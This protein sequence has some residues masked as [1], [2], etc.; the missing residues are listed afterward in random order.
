MKGYL[1][2]LNLFF[3]FFFLTTLVYSTSIQVKI[4][5]NSTLTKLLVGNYKLDAYGIVEI[6]NPSNISKVYE[7]NFPL[8]LDSL[9][10]ISKVNLIN[11]SSPVS[12]T[13]GEIRGQILNP[14][15]TLKFGYHIYGLLD[16]DV[17][18]H[19]VREGK[20]ILEYYTDSMNFYSNLIINLQKPQREG[21]IYNDDENHTINSTPGNYTNTSRLISSDIR[22]PTDF[23]YKINRINLFRS[24]VADPFLDSG[25][26]IATKSDI[27]IEPFSYSKFDFFDLNSNDDS[28]YWL[29]SDF[30][31]ISN[32]N[33]NIKYIFNIQRPLSSGSSSSSSGGG[34]SFS[35][36][37]TSNN[38]LDSIFIKK[39]VNKTL[40]KSGDEFKVILRVVNVND[41]SLEDLVIKDEI[42]LGYEIKDVS[43]GV[44]ISNKTQL[45]FYIDKV[46]PYETKI[47]EYTL[48]NKN[49]YRGVTY[50]KPA[51]LIVENQS[52]YSEGV[53]VVNELL[54]NKKVFV[55]KDIKI[56][57]D[58]YVKVTIKVKNLGS[59]NLN[60]LLVVDEIGDDVIL[61]DISK[62]FFERGSW[63]I[64]ELKS[65]EE[66]EVTYLAER[67]ANL[68]SLPN[69]YGVDK[70]DVYGT[71][72]SS[73]EVVTIYQDQP[74]TI[75][76]VGLGLAVGLLVIYLLF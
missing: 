73:D 64:K 3:L 38:V 22:N 43:S 1:N 40:I 76:K 2:Y 7:F 74:R 50:L 24:N 70:T 36:I 12:I 47:I 10:G 41:F 26:M 18:E 61:K 8:S 56:Y 35:G 39:S 68:D 16:Y 71:V 49:K 65:G 13:F 72:I 59:V 33:S 48:I 63:R 51:E 4:S 34:G 32:V 60:D 66:W 19:S 62:V 30:K 45:N 69:I 27:E 23:G 11:V 25:E 75:E 21:Y 57:D 52:F 37:L 46:D 31:I 67:G 53:L 42:P 44:K 17:Y 58:N 15:S 9:I 29:S 14:N 20:S 55:Q 54:P 6:Y 28:V 5:E